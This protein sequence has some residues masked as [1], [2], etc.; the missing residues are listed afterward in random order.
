MKIPDGNELAGL[1]RLSKWLKL[2]TCTDVTGK[3]CETVLSAAH[4]SDQEVPCE[5]VP[6]IELSAAQEWLLEVIGNAESEDPT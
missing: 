1:R 5:C 6:C 3:P 2:K 4:F